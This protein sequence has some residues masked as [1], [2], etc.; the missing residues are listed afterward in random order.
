VEACIVESTNF[1]GRREEH[2]RYW[3]IPVPG[4]N[5]EQVPPEYEGVL[6]SL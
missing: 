2:Y 6:I 1:L 4:R 3:N 5:A